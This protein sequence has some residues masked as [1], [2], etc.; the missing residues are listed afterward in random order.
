MFFYVEMTV[1]SMD[2]VINRAAPS[3]TRGRGLRYRTRG[4]RRKDT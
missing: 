4:L 1:E 3:G 2:D